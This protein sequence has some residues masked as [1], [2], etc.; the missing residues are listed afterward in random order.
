VFVSVDVSMYV[1]VSLCGLPGAYVHYQ[2]LLSGIVYIVCVYICV[3][4]CVC[5][6]TWSDWSGRCLPGSPVGYVSVFMS[7]YVSMYVS[8]YVCVC[9]FGRTGAEI[10]YQALQKGIASVSVSE[11]RCVCICHTYICI[12]MYIYICIYMYIYIYIYIYI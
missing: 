5:V 1:C 12:Y 8:V 3:Y 6:S 9:L 7:V 2:A 11:G 4:V 10:A